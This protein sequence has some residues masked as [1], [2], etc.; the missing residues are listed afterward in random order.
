MSHRPL[1]L[2]TGVGRR[3]GIGAALATRLAADGWDLAISWWGPY[4]DRVS[5][6]ADPDGIESVV[7]ECE[8]AGARV[9]RLPVDLADPEQAAALVDRAEAE[10][11]AP[12]T[13]LVLSHCESV[14]SDFRSTTVAAWDQHFAVNARAPFLLVQAY[15]AAL[16]RA[17]D[18][19]PRSLRRVIALTSDHIAYN[20]PY[21]ASKGALDRIVLGAAKELADLGVR[22]N[23]VNPGPN[24]TGWMTDETKAWVRSETPGGRLGTP[25]DT[26][27]LVGFLCSE[28]GGWIS[29]QVLHSDG[30]FSNHA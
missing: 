21:G 8:A 18:A 30:G 3:A 11:G 2:V 5:G 15:Q 25:A 13:A 17:D 28:D 6:G 16:E 9:S 27:A 29:G 12:V 14:D 19:A 22:A 4:D 26:A 23:L 10:A 20:L 7:R 1:A 24:D